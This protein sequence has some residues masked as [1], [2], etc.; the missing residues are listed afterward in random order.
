MEVVNRIGLNADNL[1]GLD[2]DGDTV[3]IGRKTG[4]AKLLKGKIC[5][6]L[7]SCIN[8][9]LALVLIL[10]SIILYLLD[11]VHLRNNLTILHNI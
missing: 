11:L 8:H 4:V 1:V 6:F 7:Q 10:I 5:E 2:S 3:M 9:R